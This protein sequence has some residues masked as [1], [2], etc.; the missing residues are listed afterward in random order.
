MSYHTV[1][2]RGKQTSSVLEDIPGI[3][4]ATRRKLI[5]KFGSVRGLRDA[6]IE[7]ISEII[8][9]AKARVVVRALTEP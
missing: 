7:D 6:S 5:R 9:L 1:L 2:K 4:P 3:G 8:G